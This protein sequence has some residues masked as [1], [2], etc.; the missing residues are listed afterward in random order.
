MTLTRPAAISYPWA[1]N[2]TSGFTHTVPTDD[3]GTGGLASWKL[4]FPPATFG[5]SP[6][7]VPPNGSDMN[8]ALNALSA[9]IQWVNSGKPA[10][11]DSAL[12][13]AIGGY[14]AGSV[15]CLS[16]GYTYVISTANAN[17]NDPNSGIGGSTH[18]APFGGTVAM[19]GNYGVD[20]GAVNAYA[21]AGTPPIPSPAPI[22]T[23]ITFVSQNANTGVSTL[24]GAALRN[25]AGGFLVA[26]DITV[27]KVYTAVMQ[28]SGNWA[29][30]STLPSQSSATFYSISSS[31]TGGITVSGASAIL[32]LSS[33]STIRHLSFTA[34]SDCEVVVG[35]SSFAVGHDD[36]TPGGGHCGYILTAQKNG[37]PEASS[38]IWLSNA[39]SG[40][41]ITDDIN[42]LQVVVNSSGGGVSG[43][44]WFPTT[45]IS[46]AA[47]NTL[48]IDMNDTYL[49]SAWIPDNWKMNVSLS[50]FG[51]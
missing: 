4:G 13:T 45:G 21:M 31:L 16:D 8:G 44:I 11:F 22:G 20:T 5:I 34:L 24:N 46:L 43:T 15:L 17:A 33:G 41:R 38:T 42:V 28:A 51:K 48:V 32:P 37:T 7:A 27:G 12:S 3:P 10:I 25:N 2:A 47:G 6:G 50:V 39:G 40:D 23:M 14:P 30:T 18:W 35:G 49:S 19:A 26:G 36:V 1:A 29:I 9:N